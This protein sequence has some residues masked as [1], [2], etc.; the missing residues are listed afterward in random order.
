MH[1]PACKVALVTAL[2]TCISLTCA[3]PQNVANLKTKIQSFLATQ[4]G[5]NVTVPESVYHVSNGTALTCGIL[6]AYRSKDLVTQQDGVE[7]LSEAEQHWYVS[8]FMHDQ[9]STIYRSYALCL[10]KSA[11]FRSPTA[12]LTPNC[13]FEPTTITEVQFAVGILNITG[14]TYAIRSGGHSP[15][16]GFASTND[17]VLIAMHKMKTVENDSATEN[18]R[19]GMGNTWGDVYGALI[20][21]ERI[22]VGGRLAPVGMALVTGGEY[23]SE[24]PILT[25]RI[26]KDFASTNIMSR[27]TF[28]PLQ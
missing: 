16:P 7:Y 3:A 19:L 8:P 2:S 18:V 10:P 28:T 23:L 24:I 4:G 11:L 22:V 14:S 9:G 21:Y 15:F 17:G 25:G 12:W 6:N 13:I 26:I 20:P 5:G 27:W 1:F